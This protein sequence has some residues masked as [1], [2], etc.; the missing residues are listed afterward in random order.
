VMLEALAARGLLQA[1]PD[2]IV[3]LARDITLGLAFKLTQ[4]DLEGD[5]GPPRAQIARAAAEIMAQVAAVA[6]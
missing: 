2:A 5:A 3:S 6:A 4:L 1:T